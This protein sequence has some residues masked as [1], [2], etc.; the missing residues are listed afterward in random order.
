MTTR[1]ICTRSYHDKLIHTQKYSPSNPA[2]PRGP[3]LWVLPSDRIDA[4]A[5]S[6]TAPPPFARVLRPWEISLPTHQS[7]PP[8]LGLSLR[9]SLPSAISLTTPSRRRYRCALGAGSRC[10]RGNSFPLVSWPSRPLIA[11][12]SPIRSNIGTLP[13]TFHP[14]QR[15][16]GPYLASWVSSRHLQPISTPGI[17][18]DLPR[19]VG[20]VARQPGIPGSFFPLYFMCSVQEVTTVCYPSI[21]SA[22]IPLDPLQSPNLLSRSS[23]PFHTHTAQPLPPISFQSTK[24]PPQHT[25]PKFRAKQPPESPGNTKSP[26]FSWVRAVSALGAHFSLILLCLPGG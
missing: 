17:T 21:F 5:P 1:K 20:W 14:S 25:D 23:A 16:P 6:H 7:R 15:L 2:G 3:L 19:L 9:F 10:K 26:S 24:E 13:S 22:Q 12:R 18:R 8:Q 4:S 11:T